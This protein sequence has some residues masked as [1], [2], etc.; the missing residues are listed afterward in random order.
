MCKPSSLFVITGRRWLG[1]YLPAVDIEE[2]GTFKFLVCR[3]RGRGG[4]QRIC[5]RGRNYCTQAQIIDDISRKVSALL[6]KVCV[7]VHVHA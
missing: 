3:L 2:W 7:C 5:I 4:K 6:V 1:T